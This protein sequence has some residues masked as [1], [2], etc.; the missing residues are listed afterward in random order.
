M[1]DDALKPYSLLS[2]HYVD[3]FRR[4]DAFTITHK[5]HHLPTRFH[6]ECPHVPFLEHIEMGTSGWLAEMESEWVLMLSV[7]KVSL[8]FSTP[9]FFSVAF[10]FID[11]VLMYLLLW[12]L[13]R[14]VE[15]RYGENEMR[16]MMTLFMNN[17]FHPSHALILA[18]FCIYFFLFVS[19]SFTFML[20]MQHI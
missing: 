8:S 19:S 12:D 20:V 6:N 15:G 7:A 9:L 18:P 4:I 2:D 11:R 5:S 17:I 3:E 1:S 13:R 16:M 10:A 14:W